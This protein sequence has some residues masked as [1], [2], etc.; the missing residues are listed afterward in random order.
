MPGR[1]VALI[2]DLDAETVNAAMDKAY[3]Q[4]VNQYNVPG[5]RK[6]KAPR[7]ILESYVGKDTLTERAVRNI[8]PDELQKAL[9]GQDIEAMDVGDV[10]ILSMDPVQVKVIVVQPPKVELGDYG[11]IR[12]EKEPVEVTQ[13]QIEEVLQ[14][15]RRDGAPWNEPAE[16]RHIQKDDMVYVDLEGYTTQGPLEEASRENFPTIVGLPRAGVPAAV[17]DELVGMNVGEEKD[18]TDTLPDDYPNEA[19]R[20][21]DATY[22]VTVRSMKEQNLPELDD[23]FAKTTGYEDVAALREA[24]E[25]NLQQRAEENAT[26]KQL[27]AVIDQLVAGSTI[28]VPDVMVDEEL[29]AMVKNLDARLKEQRLTTRQYFM[30]NGTTEAEYREANRER[31]RERVIRTQA[32]QEFARREGISVEHEEIHEEMDR[33]LESFQS[34]EL[35]AAKKVLDT[36]EA[37]HDIEDRIFQ[38]KIVDRLTGIAEGRIEAARPEEAESEAKAASEPKAEAASDSEPKAEAETAA[39]AGD[40]VDAG[41]VAEVLGTGAVDTK[42]KR[43]TG[44]AKG[45]GTPEDAPAVEQAEEASKS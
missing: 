45:G 6:G 9:D 21:L 7:Y 35:E 14:Q 23:E 25:R 27:D 8:L 31:A 33:M 13:E 40:E 26:T 3:R 12:V 20:G 10:E 38:R 39:S 34:E 24:V 41:G 36:H 28:E 29:D 30:F 16:P 4:M 43:A 19:Q 37:H 44:K 15:L 32:L 11:S 5:F 17:S 18:V 42:S 2:I 22:H 1:Q